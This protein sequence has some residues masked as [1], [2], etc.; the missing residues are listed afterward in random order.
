MLAVVDASAG[1][2]H[3]GAWSCFATGRAGLGAI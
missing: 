2:C 3:T 1:V